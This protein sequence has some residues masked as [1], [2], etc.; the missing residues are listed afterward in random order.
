[1]REGRSPSCVRSQLGHTCILQCTRSRRPEYIGG[2][3]T[4]SSHRDRVFHLILLSP[5]S[6]PSSPAL[7]Q[8]LTQSEFYEATWEV[9]NSP[10]TS[11]T[12][13]GPIE[14]WDTSGVPSFKRAFTDFRKEDGKFSKDGNLKAA[15]FNGDVSKWDTS[16]ATSLYSTFGGAAAFNSDV[17][18]W[19]TSS[20]T[21]LKFT[22]AGASSFT[23]TG[24]DLWN[25]NNVTDRME[26]TQTFYNT[27]LTSCNKRKIA[28]AWNNTVF[29]FL[30]NY[31]AATCSGVSGL[32]VVICWIGIVR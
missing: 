16:S 15:M 25:T 14:D 24:V 27:A 8:P 19:I 12:K 32:Y 30:R 28:D 11:V 17:S 20:V 18:A 6:P 31:W 7:T 21:S 23:G 4:R 5:S 29:T 9:V 2:N 22:F 13:W 10:S 26:T 3:H 1:M